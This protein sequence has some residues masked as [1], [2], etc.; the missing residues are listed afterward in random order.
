MTHPCH[1]CD[2]CNSRHGCDNGEQEE[3]VYPQRTAS[4]RDCGF[5]VLAAQLVVGIHQ[6]RASRYTRVGLEA[7]PRG[8]SCNSPVLCFI[9]NGDAHGQR[10]TPQRNRGIIFYKFGGGGCGARSRKYPKARRIISALPY[11]LGLTLRCQRADAVRR[12]R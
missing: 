10:E 11:Q 9:A 1:T 7:S 8:A 2:T 4:H 6:V 5:R 12:H 3:Y